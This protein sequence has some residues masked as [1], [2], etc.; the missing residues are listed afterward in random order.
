MII[1][2]F[3]MHRIPLLAMLLIAQSAFTQTEDSKILPSLP[4][5]K[6]IEFEKGD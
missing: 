2:P 4:L 5:R 1:N 3:P 6:K